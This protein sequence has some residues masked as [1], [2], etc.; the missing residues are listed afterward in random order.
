MT[1][2][3]ATGHGVAIRVKTGA[4][5]PIFKARSSVL[6][7]FLPSETFTL[8]QGQWVSLSVSRTAAKE[9]T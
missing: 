5:P 4:F 2:A 8:F 9:S 7:D 1:I 6:G 3:A